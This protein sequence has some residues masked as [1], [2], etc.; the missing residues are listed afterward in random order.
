MMTRLHSHATTS[1]LEPRA[2][3][4][5]GIFFAARATL[6]YEILLTRIFSATMRYQFVCARRRYAADLAGAALGSVPTWS[7]ATALWCGWLCDGAAF[8]AF[9]RAAA[10]RYTF[11]LLR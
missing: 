3:T 10:L 9:R 7:I 1:P 8:V 5:I 4:Y 11:G 2:V 6:M